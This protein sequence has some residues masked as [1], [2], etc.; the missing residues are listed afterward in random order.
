MAE[1]HG[2]LYGRRPSTATLDVSMQLS[3][4]TSAQALRSAIDLQPIDGPDGRV[5]PPTYPPPDGTNNK[6]P[7]HVVETL[8]TGQKRLLSDGGASQANWQESA[9]VAASS[10]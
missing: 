8:P 4:L 2:H 9:M 1:C 10:A 5:F 7:R 6:N 3:D